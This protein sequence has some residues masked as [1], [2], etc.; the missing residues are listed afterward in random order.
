MG[1]GL[2][3]AKEG[4][5]LETKL[6]EF[7]KSPPGEPEELQ[8]ARGLIASALGGP[9]PP[10]LR[11]SLLEMAGLLMLGVSNRNLRELLEKDEG[12]SFVPKV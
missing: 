10:I 9:F 3:E 6:E 1:S 11:D 2:K 5:T 7:I 12:K 8:T 4:M